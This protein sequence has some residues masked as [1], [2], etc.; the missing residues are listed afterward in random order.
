VVDG[1]RVQAAVLDEKEAL[2]RGLGDPSLG[3]E[4]QD[5]VEALA[6]RALLRDGRA[7]VAGGDLDL[8]REVG[9]ILIVSATWRRAG[10]RSPS[11]LA[12]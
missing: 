4:K 12:P 5:V 1:S 7:G 6:T 3:V 11:R 2:R 9:G 10:G 8:G